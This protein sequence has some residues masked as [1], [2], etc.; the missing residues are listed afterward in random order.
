MSEPVFRRVG[1]GGAGN[2]YSKKDV[3]EVQKNE[4]AA[5]AQDIEAQKQ[6]VPAT[7]VPP[8]ASESTTQTYAR[9]GRGG[10]G[11]FKDQASAAA[12]LRL[13]REEAER[14]KAVVAANLA[15]AKH[16]FSGRGGAGNWS[17]GVTP[18]GAQQQ[19]E[20]QQRVED[21]EMKVL[22]DVEAGLALPPPAYH[23]PERDT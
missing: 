6:A 7:T 2:W 12:S 3:E 14:T 4:A 9:S 22:R 21:L 17:D 1:R 18:L 5:A 15:K 19:A 13:E 16:P 23:V 11:N 8:P 20:E 10:A